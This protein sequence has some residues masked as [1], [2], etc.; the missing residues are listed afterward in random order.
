MFLSRSLLWLRVRIPTTS[1]ILLSSRISE[2]DIFEEC[3]SR[4]TLRRYTLG[5]G[6]TSLLSVLKRSLVVRLVQ[7]RNDVAFVHGAEVKQ[8]NVVKRGTAF[9]LLSNYYR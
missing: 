8:C 1:A 7:D 2:L 9:L 4:L 3:R 6:R 5:I